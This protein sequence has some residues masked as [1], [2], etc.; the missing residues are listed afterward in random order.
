MCPVVSM[1]SRMTTLA[2][3][4]I[5]GLLLLTAVL[6]GCAT[7]ALR[8]GMNAEL[9]Q[10]FDRAVVAY[11]RALQEDPNNGAARAGLERSRLR[12]ALEHFARGRRF[13]DSGRLNEALVELQLAAE[14][15]PTD[16]NVTNLLSLVT[17]EI[18]TK[19]AVAREGKTALE[20]LIERSRTMQPPGLELPSD[21]R[22]PT[23]LTFRDASA[24]DIY[25]A[26]AR[27]A[28]LNI[29]FDPQFRDQPVT[30]DLRNAS[31]Q[32][33]LDS[34][35]MATRNFYRVTGQRTI[36]VIPDTPAKRTEY[37]DEV[38]RTFYLSNADVKETLDLLRI[39]IDNRRLAPIT[40]KTRL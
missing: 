11:T 23:A 33:A 19:A 37:E 18:E 15:N 32:D 29:V 6:A 28:N 17:K 26:L 4:R 3:R 39:V 14:L 8:A 24:R 30:I 16:P 36:T 35:S 22:L 5:A 27:F 25:T 21:V 10:D 38:V 12:A 31:I 1:S 40:A 7:G 20:A 2:N 34:L 13:Y 9:A